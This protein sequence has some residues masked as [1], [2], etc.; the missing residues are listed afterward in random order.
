MLQLSHSCHST[1]RTV[2]LFSQL[3]TAAR[4]AGRQCART[5]GLARGRALQYMVMITDSFQD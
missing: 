3:F 5:A 1:L 4:P 2:I